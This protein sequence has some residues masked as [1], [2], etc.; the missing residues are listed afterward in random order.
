MEK[1]T[2]ILI[3]DENAEVRNRCREALTL[4]GALVEECGLKGFTVGGAQVSEK[5]AGFVI[6]VGGATASDV[7][8]VIEHC[9]KTVF[10]TKGVMLEPEV[11]IIGQES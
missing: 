5:H 4:R 6:N 2:K 8:D 9:Q 10:E 11:E 7:I 3:A 1:D